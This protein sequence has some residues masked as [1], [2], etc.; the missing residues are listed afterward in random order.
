MCFF[1]GVGVFKRIFFY[2][3]FNRQLSV[4]GGN[5]WSGRCYIHSPPLSLVSQQI[6]F[7]LPHGVLE[8]CVLASGRNWG[9][10]WWGKFVLGMNGSFRTDKA[11]SDCP[12]EYSLEGL[13][14]KLNILAT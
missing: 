7:F 14:L 12:P 11:V 10:A 4:M 3:L 2:N 5:V 13:M 6:S 8:S 1:E 9:F